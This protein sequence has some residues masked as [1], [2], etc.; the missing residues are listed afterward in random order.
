MK[1]ARWMVCAGAALAVGGC[2]G[3]V[4]ISGTVLSYGSAPLL[5]RV[6]APVS[7]VPVSQGAGVG[8]AVA[9]ALPAGLTLDPASGA[10]TGT[11][12]AVVPQQSYTVTATIGGVPVSVRVELAVGAVLPAEIAALEDG[13][14]AER[15]VSLPSTAAKMA[16]APDGRVLFTELL[17]GQ[18]RVVAADGTL[19]AAP[20]ATVPVLGGGHLGLLGIALSPDFATDGW[21][22][23][24]AC[25]PAGGGKA[26]R[27]RLLR[28]RAVGDKGQDE[29]VLLDDLPVSAINNGGALCFDRKGQL[30]LS[31]GDVEDP[32]LAQDDTRPAGKILRI[33]PEDGGIPPD[34]PDPASYVFASGLRN[35][36]AL[37]LHPVVDSMYVAD[38]GPASDDELNLLQ[39]GRNF[40]WGAP[41]GQSFGAQ[42]GAVLRHWSDVVVPTG[43]AIQDPA[44]P[45]A[46]PAPFDEALFLSLYDEQVVERFEL[47]G[48]LRTDIDR[49]V[50]WL[51][52]ADSGTANTPVDVQRGPQGRI[53]VLTFGGLFRIDRIR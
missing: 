26:D 17:T 19:R 2:S 41:V 24:Y 12:S 48:V 53:W 13:F 52:F 50:E 49:E 42:A 9:P 3:S 39:A 35:A 4:Q 43:L 11:P 7:H 23:A 28:W 33:R 20:F 21:V 14:A 8:F 25:T 6:G 10:I 5:W 45:S 47:S 31:I 37:A 18:I 1:S 32:L 22:F 34:N 40:E 51:R 29:T 27:G 44:A 36:F 15:V 16:V 46:W 38:N 30:L